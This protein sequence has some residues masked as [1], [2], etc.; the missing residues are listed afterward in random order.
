MRWGKHTYTAPM[1][2]LT[3][4]RLLG[5]FIWA[6]DQ[7]TLDNE[8]LDAVLWP[9]GL[10]KFSERNGAGNDG[11]SWDTQPVTYC[12]WSGKYLCPIYR[13]TY[14]GPDA[15]CG[16]GCSG[17]FQSAT[18]VRCGLADGGERLEQELCCPRTDVPDAEFCRWS[19]PNS[20]FL[21]LCTAPVGCRS[22][23]VTMASND[24]CKS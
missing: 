4:Y 7:D 24:H 19:Y 23:E 13:Y 6:I 10:G 14:L 22:D 3:S 17:A 15:D 9:D 16:S 11:N 1:L 20:N 8:L 21:G 5:L 2:Q 12:H 18:T